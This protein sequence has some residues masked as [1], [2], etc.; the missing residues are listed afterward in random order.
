MLDKEMCWF[1]S[2]RRRVFDLPLERLV[3]SLEAVFGDPPHI[4]HLH[5]RIRVICDVRCC[6]FPV[7]ASRQLTTIDSVNVVSGAQQKHSLSA[8]PPLNGSSSS[9]DGQKPEH[10]SCSISCSDTHS[11]IV[12][13]AAAL[14]LG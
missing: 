8:I 12:I 3:E 2:Y 1:F 4:E 11:P 10:E 6:V 7:F 13:R 14:R 5:D 9:Y